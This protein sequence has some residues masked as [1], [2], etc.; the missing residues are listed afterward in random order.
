MNL[1]IL[2]ERIRQKRK[3]KRL[4]QAELAD[5]MQISEMTLRRWET[6][7]SSPRIEDIQ[8]LAKE[9]ATSVDYLMGLN[10]AV[11]LQVEKGTNRSELSPTMAYWGGV[12]DNARKAVNDGQNLRLIYSLLADAAGT[13]KAAMA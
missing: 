8:Q 10:E 6:G 7:K 1:A 2:S 12:L 13:V 4:T 3:A 9:L 11:P 5:Q